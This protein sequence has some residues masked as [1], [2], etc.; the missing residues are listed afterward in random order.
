MRFFTPELYLRYNSSDDQVADRADAEWEEA[1]RGYHHHLAEIKDLMPSQVRKLTDLCL[2]DAEVLARAEEAQAGG[3]L[4]ADFHYPFPL[5][6]WSSTAVIS[7]QRNAEVVC[8]FYS[9]WDQV[10]L[11][12]PPEEWPFSKLNEHWLY[13]ELGFAAERRGPFIHRVLFSTG[14]VVEIPFSSVVI[15]RFTLSKGAVA[16]AAT[17]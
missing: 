14:V 15:H 2:H 12:S 7:V 4:F 1:V 17:A 9:L 16:V 8:L 11:Q 6:L 10:R 3:S 13:D 5:P